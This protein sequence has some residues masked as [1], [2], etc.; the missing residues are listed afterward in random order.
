MAFLV[1]SFQ[2]A[3]SSCHKRR[4]SR[5]VDK[6][7]NSSCWTWRNLFGFPRSCSSASIYAALKSIAL[8]HCGNWSCCPPP[9]LTAPAPAPHPASLAPRDLLEKPPAVRSR[10][11]WTVKLKYEAARG[12][13]FWVML[14]GWIGSDRIECQEPGIALSDHGPRTTDHG[15]LGPRTA[16]QALASLSYSSIHPSSDPAPFDPLDAIVLFYFALKFALTRC[17]N[18]K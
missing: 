10:C 15:I 7:N 12:G 16:E 8:P 13:G 14:C 3:V 2:F 11:R 1:G 5:Q 17:R 6:E 4:N 18:W 9:P